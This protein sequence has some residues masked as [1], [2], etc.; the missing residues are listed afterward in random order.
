MNLTLGQFISKKRE[1][2]GYKKLQFSSMIGVG[3][4]TL[5]SWEQDRFK[6]AGKNMYAL[7]DVLKFSADEVRLYF[8]DDYH[9]KAFELHS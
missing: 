5:R 8:R 6:P 9:G 3:N 7:I 1:E 2:F 4:D